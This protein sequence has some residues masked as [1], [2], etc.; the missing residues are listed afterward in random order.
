MA[1]TAQQEEVPVMDTSIWEARTGHSQAAMHQLQWPSLLVLS[2]T[3][4]TEC[5]LLPP[6]CLAS[7]D[8]WD[9]QI[10]S[11]FGIVCS[12]GE[13][14]QSCCS[15]L[16]P[17]HLWACPPPPQT[18]QAQMGFL[19]CSYHPFLQHYLWFEESNPSSFPT[20]GNVIPKFLWNEDSVKAEEWQGSPPIL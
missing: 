19:P 14:S 9:T 6:A 18:A 5:F 10:C 7:H 2:L 17:G 16:L 4:V 13:N 1:G 3:W 15:S 20:P 8:L 12:L 11:H